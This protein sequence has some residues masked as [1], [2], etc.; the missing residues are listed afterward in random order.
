MHTKE[1]KFKNGDTVLEIITG[2][3]GIITG[4]CFYITGCNQYLVTGESKEGKEAYAVWVDEGRLDKLSKPNISDK[5]AQHEDGA[6]KTP[7]FGNNR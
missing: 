1:F 6:D 4:T 3:V 5:I 2:F 7:G